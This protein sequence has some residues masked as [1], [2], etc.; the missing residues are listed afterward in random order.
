[1]NTQPFRARIVGPLGAA[2]LTLFLSACSG[3]P[4]DQADYERMIDRTCGGASLNSV[5]RPTYC[6]RF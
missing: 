3:M 1:M 4:A 5:D 2:L 6:D